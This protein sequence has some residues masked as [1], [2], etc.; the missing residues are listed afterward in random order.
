MSRRLDTLTV[1]DDDGVVGDP[2]LFGGLESLRGHRRDGD[3]HLGTGVGELLGDLTCCEQRVDRRGRRTRA[4]HSVEDG[5][6]RGN[7]RRQNS[8]D[9]ADADAARRE[10]ACG[11]VDLA[12]QLAVRGLR[13]GLGVDERDA[14]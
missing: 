6:E 11:G 13:V 4:Q 14:V 5:G 7:V 10:S 12:D 1:E 2:D 8:D 3:E 9:I